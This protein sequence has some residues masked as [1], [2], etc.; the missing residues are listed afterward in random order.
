MPVEETQEDIKTQLDQDTVDRET[1]GDSQNPNQNTTEDDKQTQEAPIRSSEA[2]EE[3]GIRVC[4]DIRYDKYFKMKQFGVP[5]EAVK[6][7]M[8]AEGLDASLL[9]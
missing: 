5:A 4:D 8:S 7:K 9:E 1:T 2:V 6:L 3:N